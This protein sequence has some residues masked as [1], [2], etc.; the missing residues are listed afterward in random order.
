MP[1]PIIQLPFAALLFALVSAL[2]P[3]V[4]QAYVET[5]AELCH[6]I[7]H[8]MHIEIHKHSLR[9]DGED[10]IY[11]T[12]G[13]ICLAIV[14]N[15]T[16]SKH[17]PP[18]R[19]Y[20]LTKRAIPIDDDED[21]QSDMSAIAHMMT[22][23]GICEVFTEDFQLEL[24]GLMYGKVLQRDAKDLA[25]EFCS[26]EAFLQAGPPP[27]PPKKR[28]EGGE[29]GGKRA[30]AK[31]AAGKQ[32]KKK[33]AKEGESVQDSMDDLLRKYDTDGSISNLM[34][35]ERENPTAMF[36]PEQ[37]AQLQSGIEDVRCDVCVAAA[38]VAANRA[39]KR[40]LLREEDALSDMVGLLCYETPPDSLDHYPKYPGNPPL[41]GEL[42]S[43][44]YEEAAGKWA[45]RRRPKGAP[46]EE[47]GEGGHDYE[48]LVMKHAM[49]SKACKQA[50]YERDEFT[51]GGE[52]GDDDDADLAELLF[53]RPRDDAAQIAER[54][55]RP[56][57]GAASSS[58]GGSQA[59]AG[60]KDEV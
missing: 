33:K 28:K 18:R 42:Y 2:S 32:Q 26:S 58:A 20:E 36:E 56:L 4:R 37:R 44:K 23:K 59:G 9:K 51:G 29:N 40:K 11:E 48:A 54:Y 38:K 24:S 19:A 27:P 3:E 25:E 17:E 14:Q 47:T 60:A 34:E 53:Q 7:I 49:I 43:V 13:A 10:D 1:R 6:A 30:K 22:L 39:K 46:K 57:C 50:V 55:C 12:V 41:W 16:L 21:A 52:G 5:R 15:Y 31:A 35:M 45:M 8:E